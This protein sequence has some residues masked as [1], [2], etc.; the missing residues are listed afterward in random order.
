MIGSMINLLAV[1]ICVFCK[2]CDNSNVM[3]TTG[4]LL[5]WSSEAASNVS[6]WQTCIESFGVRKVSMTRTSRSY[7]PIKLCMEAFL[8]LIDVT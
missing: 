4:T 7:V 1:S 6:L 5:H 3:I 2:Q 8:L